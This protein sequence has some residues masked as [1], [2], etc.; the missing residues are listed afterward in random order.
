MKLVELS[1][2]L[3]CNTRLIEKIQPKCEKCCYYKLCK[4]LTN[5]MNKHRVKLPKPQRISMDHVIHG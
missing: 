2:A 1:G 5:I 3:S 4:D